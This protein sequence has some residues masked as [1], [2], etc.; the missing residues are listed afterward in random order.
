MQDNSSLSN[1]IKGIKM[2]K[3]LGI[4]SELNEQQSK[5][6]IDNDPGSKNYM[7]NVTVSEVSLKN[8]VEL[9]NFSGRTCLIISLFV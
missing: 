6:I 1:L 5:S 8:Y 3:A 4:A 2:K 7:D 9:I